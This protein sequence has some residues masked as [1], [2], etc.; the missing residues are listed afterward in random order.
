M[1]HFF[2]RALTRAV[3]RIPDILHAH[4][5]YPCGLAAVQVARQWGIPCVLTLH[6]SDVHHY[7]NANAL[8]RA[9]FAR[10]LR[11]MDRVFAV[12]GALAERAEQLSGCRPDVLP[13]GIPLSPASPTD[14]AAARAQ[15]GLPADGTLLLYVG[16]LCAAKGLHE[17]QAALATLAD[18]EVTGILVGEGPLRRRIAATPHLRCV[19]AQPHAQIPLY[20][21]AADLLVLPSY[22]EG[23]PTVLVEAG[24]ARL[25]VI[26]TT[27][28]GIPELLADDRGLLIPP[29]HASAIVQAVRQLRAEPSAARARAMRLDAYVR[30]HYDM[31]ANTQRLVE[32]YRA[33]LC[34]KERA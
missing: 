25:P 14:R 18:E 15:L 12:S 33:L 3:T 10:A 2:A 28:G 22:A 30:A 1:H 27:V 4:F 20:M 7:P 23:L 31:A 5:A 21:A 16:N 6:G 24:A 11:Q 17:L 13:L 32:C 26:A 9:R 8:A 29:R 19:G 34:E